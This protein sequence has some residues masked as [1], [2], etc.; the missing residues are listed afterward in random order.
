MEAISVLWATFLAPLAV[1]IILAAYK[2]YL[3]RRK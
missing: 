2:D 1:G 3:R